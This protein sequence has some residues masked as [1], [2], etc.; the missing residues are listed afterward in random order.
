MQPAGSRVAASVALGVSL[1]LAVTACGSSTATPLT[2]PSASQPAPSSSAGRA[3]GSGD[4]LGALTAAARQEGGLTTIG[5]P[6]DW[7]NYGEALKTFQREFGITV[8]ELNPDA[9]FGD[10]VAAIRPAAS[11]PADVPDVPDVI[12]VSL[13]VAAAA[14]KAGLL[15]PYKVGSWDTIPVAAKD[16]AGAWTGDYFGVLA[17]ESNHNAVPTPPTD[18]SELLRPAYANDVALAG[19]PRVSDQAIQ[20]VY[21]AALANGGT[22]DNAKPG[23]AFFAALKKAG[24]LLPTIAG[25]GT[26]DSGTTP[27]SIRW[28]YNALSHRDASAGD[29]AI[30]VTVPAHGR[31]AGFDVQ[32][33]SKAAAHP[34]AARLWLEFL[35]S[36]EGQLI[37]LKGNCNP[38][39]LAD[40]L[41]RDAVPADL[42]AALPDIDG[43]VFP[44]LPQLNAASALIVK[45]WDGTVGLDIK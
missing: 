10:Q 7:C 13:P 36:D 41:D 32:A 21:A 9:G 28:S 12:D 42:M 8:T 24:N 3:T 29:P 25:P 22:L 17:F 37:W 20:T 39:R 23:L 44:S 19:D 27:L 34:N 11:S 18:W 2:P 5:L 40:L 1:A 30:D 14:A 26:I 15:A 45:G 16:P 33:I 31:L 35:Y 4:P 38:I 43:V 6:H